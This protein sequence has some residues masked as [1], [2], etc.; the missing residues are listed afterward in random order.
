MFAKRSDNDVA[1]SKRVA[2]LKN[3]K[4]I[5]STY[6][7]AVQCQAVN[8]QSPTNGNM[9]AAAVKLVSKLL[10]LPSTTSQP[11]YSATQSHENP[12]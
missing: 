11:L 6:Y 7:N 12:K 2:I 1:R 3:T 9:A 8:R 4:V 5:H 10:P